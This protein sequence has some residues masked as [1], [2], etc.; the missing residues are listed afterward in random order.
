MANVKG[1]RNEGEAIAVYYAYGDVVD[2][3]T[4]ALSQ[5]HTIDAQKVCKDLE[6][7]MNDDDVKAVV[8]RINTGGG[9]AYASEQIWHSMKQLKAKKPVVVSMG[10]MA[11]SGGYYISCIGNYIYAEPTTLTGS[12]GIFGMFPDASQLLTE[13]LGVK[14]EEIKTNKFSTFGS[15]SRPFNEEEMSYLNKYIQR[16]YELFRSRVAE[17][18]KMSVEEVEKIAQ[19][20]VWLG[21]DAL[22]IKLV[23]ALGGLDDAIKKAAELAKLDKYHSVAYPEPE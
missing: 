7:L 3:A 18:R 10:G 19:G 1:S 22:K 15:M 8:L 12:I 9:S 6:Q 16:G 14:F 2:G 11:A 4:G 21:Q 17:G 20:H 5:G 13:K 23:D